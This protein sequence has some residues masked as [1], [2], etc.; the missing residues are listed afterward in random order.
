MLIDDPDWTYQ[1]M[2]QM[3]EIDPNDGAR[4]LVSLSIPEENVVNPGLGA[5]GASH[6]EITPE[7]SISAVGMTRIPPQPNRPPPMP[8]FGTDQTL[9]APP[10]LLAL[11]DDRPPEFITDSGV[12]RL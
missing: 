6:I 10:G 2:K 1:E 8:A 4:T 11:T 3:A 7:D 12:G 9:T 5:S